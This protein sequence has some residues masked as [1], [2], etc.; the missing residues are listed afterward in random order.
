MVL[1]LYSANHPIGG[2]LLVGVVLSELRVPFEL[3]QLDLSVPAREHK[4]AS[5]MAL[6]PFG[7]VPAIVCPPHSK[8]SRS[9]TIRA[10]RRRLRPLRIARDLAAAL[11]EQAASV[12]YSHFQPHALKIYLHGYLFPKINLPYDLLE[13]NTAKTALDVTLDVYEATLGKQAYLCGNEITLVDL[14]HV[15][16]G[17][18]LLAA[19]YDGL[20]TSQ[21]P[22]VQR[23]WTMVSSRS[24]LTQYQSGWKEN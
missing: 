1:K 5:Y 3:A 18:H 4:T 11:F 7:Q 13:L 8:L 15:A 16:F 24:T 23:W 12:E 9:L 20:G 10:G 22:N 17:A 19:G 6:Q 21:R 14:F 2:S